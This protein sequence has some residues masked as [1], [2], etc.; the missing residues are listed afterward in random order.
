MTLVEKGEVVERK[1]LTVLNEAVQTRL[2]EIESQLKGKRDVKVTKYKAEIER[3]QAEAEDHE[4]QRPQAH[5]GLQGLVEGALEHR[6][7]LDADGSHGNDSGARSLKA[8]ASAHF[9]RST[10]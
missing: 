8:A 10:K 4:K 6:D 9:R 3:I 5:E 7:E 1:H 2:G